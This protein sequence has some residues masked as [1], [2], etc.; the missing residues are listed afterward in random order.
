MR[1]GCLAYTF[2][3]RSG[4]VTIGDKAGT[5]KDGKLTIDGQ[6][7]EGT[8]IPAAGTRFTINEHQHYDFSGMCGL[9]LGCTVT[10]KFLTLL[11]DGQFVLSHSTT[12]TMGDPGMGPF[13]YVG[14]FPPDQHGSYEVQDGGRIKLAYADGTVKVET[15]AVLHNVNTGAPDPVGEGVLIGADNYYPDPSP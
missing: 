2:D 9:I 6:T 1:D 8:Q 3:E 10:K 14:N 5:F 4:A 7:Y 11:P 12:S 15:F 13:T